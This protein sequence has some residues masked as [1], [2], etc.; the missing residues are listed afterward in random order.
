MNY[1][2][3]IGYNFLPTGKSDNGTGLKFVY[4]LGLSVPRLTSCGPKYS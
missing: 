1:S 2:N 3:I 4:L